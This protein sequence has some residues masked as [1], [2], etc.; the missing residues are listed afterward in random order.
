MEKF[1]DFAA[2]TYGRIIRGVVGLVLIV[3]GI[4][5][6]HDIW[7]WILVILGAIFLASGVLGICAL[8]LLVNR[9][10]TYKP[11]DK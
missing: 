11:S 10:L 3:L 6:A 1:V 7:V 4:V 2:G 9:P 5:A 8:N